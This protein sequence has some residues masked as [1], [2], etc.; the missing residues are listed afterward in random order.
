M[1]SICKFSSSLYS[2]IIEDTLMNH[3]ST[4]CLHGKV[5]LSECY[6]RLARVAILRNEV[7]PIARQHYVIYLTLSA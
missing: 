3:L 7:A 2:L 5:I 6:F 1:L 4:A